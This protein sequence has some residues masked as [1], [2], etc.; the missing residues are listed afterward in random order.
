MNWFRKGDDGK[1]LWPGFGDNLRVLEWI[2]ER[3]QGTAQAR[4]TPIGFVPGRGDLDLQGLD[5]DEAGIDALLEVDAEG[6][7]TEVADIGHY[8]ESFGARTPARLHAEQRRVADALAA[9]LEPVQEQTA[10]IG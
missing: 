3:C 10:A 1:F 8:L 7:S 5:L 6:W 9:A 2:L 4:D